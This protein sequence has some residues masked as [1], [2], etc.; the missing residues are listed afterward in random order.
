MKYTIMGAGGYIGSKLKT[1]L[2]ER[3]DR[4]LSPARGEEL[5]LASGAEDLG[6]VI[7]AI[8]LTGDFRSRFFDTVEAHV[9]L[10]AHVLKHARFSSF[11]YLSSTR[12][13][14]DCNLDH[15]QSEEDF[16]LVKPSA[17]GIYNISKLLGESICLAQ[18]NTA[19]R[20]ARLSNVYSRD[21]DRTSFLGHV[22]QDVRGSGSCKILESP[23][24]EKDYVHVE[25]V[26]KLLLRIAPEGL[27]RLYNVASGEN[28][29]HADIAAKLSQSS[30]ATITFEENS[31][32]RRFPHI[33]ISKIRSEF[34]FEPQNL[35]NELPNLL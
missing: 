12:A 3:G 31:Q 29:S 24:S 4:V 25:D 15:A 10:L 33:D 16:V 7:Y 6:H 26:V 28:V 18:S 13:Y 14:Q 8:G 22:L 32:V 23:K 30:G 11:L 9:T 5:Q 27:N 21:M 35:L 20:I 1:A 2:E 17:D 34:G 19:V